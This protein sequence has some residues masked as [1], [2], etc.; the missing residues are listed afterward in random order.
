[1]DNTTH[2][3]GFG[4]NIIFYILLCLLI[5]YAV[6]F[7]LRGIY[8]IFQTVVHPAEQ[9]QDIEMVRYVMD[10]PSEVQINPMEDIEQ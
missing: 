1:M 7:F 2:I 3:I 10:N 6:Q 5:C 9:Q 4:L 8:S